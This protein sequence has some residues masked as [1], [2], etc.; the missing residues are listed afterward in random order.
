VISSSTSLATSANLSQ[1]FVAARQDEIFAPLM[2]M[3]SFL[4]VL[5]ILTDKSSPIWSVAANS[6]T[7]DLY[8]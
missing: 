6:G 4:A 5:C 1:E 2:Q 7:I 3:T 8:T